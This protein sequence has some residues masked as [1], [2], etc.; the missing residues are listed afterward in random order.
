LIR[1]LARYCL[2]GMGGQLV[3]VFKDKA[4]GLPPLNT[5][6]AR[7][8]METTKIYQALKGVR[9]RKPVDLVALEKLMVGFSQLVGRAD[10]GS[11]RSISIHCLPR[12]TIWWRSTPASSCT[13]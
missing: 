9:G 12:R 7:R 3:E 13:T 10:A 4:L 8:M 6:L 2:F 1:S 11:R 5:T